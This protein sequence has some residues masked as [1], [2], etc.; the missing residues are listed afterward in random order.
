MSNEGTFKNIRVYCA[1]SV[2]SS[3]VDEIDVSL[4]F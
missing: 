3:L 4:D 1:L 2:A